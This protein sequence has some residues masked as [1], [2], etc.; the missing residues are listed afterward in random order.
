M[1]SKESACCRCDTF[2]FCFSFFL[3]VLLT[4]L[5]IVFDPFPGAVKCS[6]ELEQ[7]SDFSSEYAKHAEL[8]VWYKTRKDPIFSE[9]QRFTH[10]EIMK[11]GKFVWGRRYSVELPPKTTGIRADICIKESGKVCSA[12]RPKIKISLNNC[13][14][15]NDKIRFSDLQNSG[16]TARI[17]RAFFDFKDVSFPSFDYIFTPVVFLFFFIIILFLPVFLE[18]KYR[19]GFI[20]C[21]AAI[22]VFPAL[23]M[24]HRKMDPDENRNLT[25]FPKRFSVNGMSKYFKQTE[26]A[27]NDHFLGRKK[28]IYLSNL[29]QF[30]FD[31]KGNKEV[32]IGD[33][34]EWF[35]F[36]ESIDSFMQ[37]RIDEAQ[38]KMIG[39]N[40]N[41]INRYAKKNGKFFIFVIA[42]DKLRIYGEKLGWIKTQI[43]H[44]DNDIDR[45]VAYLRSHYDFPVIYQRKNLLEQKKKSQRNIYLR[46]DTHWNQEGAY[47]GFYLPVMG[48]LP[49]KYGRKNIVKEWKD[50]SIPGE[51]EDLA[52]LFSSSLHWGPLSQIV[53]WK[54]LPQIVSVPVFFEKQPSGGS[55]SR[56]VLMYTNPAGNG[57]KLFAFRDSFA[58]AAIP[59]LSRAFSKS[60]FVWRNTPFDKDAFLQSDVIICEVVERF[61]YSF[62]GI[63]LGMEL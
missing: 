45:L 37:K 23:K 54:P 28:L 51:K 62:Q 17:Y 19:Q 21:C 7:N 9:R 35:F 30:I 34:K 15:K 11:Q 12:A 20:L 14:V 2:R 10:D 60:V 13:R 32:L 27:F 29:L 43:L 56:N 4:V 42:P 59:F 41:V 40:L 55:T 8:S 44:K 6:L 50:Q 46:H 18:G 39:D 25:S 53:H 63:Q 48:C 61:V 3:A 1:F 38:M 26:N 49:E 24:D 47:Y 36:R 33:D 31:R 57:L 16:G 22:A 5:F 52:K 58:T